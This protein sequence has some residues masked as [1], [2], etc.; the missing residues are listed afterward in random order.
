MSRLRSL[1]AAGGLV[2]LPGAAFAHPGSGHAHGF[3]DGFIHPITGPDHMLA[4]LAVGLLAARLRGRALW[5]APL[6]FVAMMAA[7]GALAFAGVSLPFVE[8]AILLSVGVLGAA[9]VLRLNM[10]SILAAAL[11]GFFA[12][13]HGHAHVAE[14]PAHTGVLAFGLGF[15]AATVLLHAAGAGVGFAIGRFT[16]RRSAPAP[17]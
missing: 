7:G 9:V 4:M 6:A 14:M 10:P 11:A 12:V 8:A 15:I 1:A 13:F 17:A 5:Q 16:R 2:M 3:V